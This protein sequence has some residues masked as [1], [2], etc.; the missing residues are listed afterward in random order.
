MLPYG[1]H[2]IE[3]DDIAAVAE[4]L[5]SDFL[6][7]GPKI[8][9]FEKALCEVTGAQYAVVCSSG[10][11]ALHLIARAMDL[12]PADCVIVPSITFLATANSPHETGARIVFA[13][14]N[15]RTGLMEPEH[16]EAALNRCGSHTPR[17]VFPV[18]LRGEGVNLKALRSVA[19]HNQ[20]KVIGDSC[21]A[22]GGEINGSPTGACRYEDAA[23]FSFHPV[24]TI[25]MGEGGAITTNDPELAEKTRRLRTHNVEWTA[26]I[27]PW[28]YEMPAPGFNY[29]ASALHC[30]LGLSQLKKLQRFV[31]RR[32]QLAALYDKA[33]EGLSPH[34]SVIPRQGHTRSG[35]HLYSVLIDFNALGKDRAQVM[36]E[37]KERRIGTQVHYIPVHTQPYYRALEPELHLPGAEDYY[38]QTLSLPLFPA[39]S[40]EDVGRVVEALK[41]VLV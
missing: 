19:D 25:A 15:A 31:D 6:T 28:A 17:A 24:K 23:T 8:E 5:R 3:E 18:H 7:S 34:L 37:L 16:L 27:G 33:L 21:H 9:E 13:D 26:D 41:D 20:I 1:R 29:R 32:A 11:A 38:A 14:V 30:A 10:T 40:D 12:G 36:N 4:T 35:W 39:M 22:I 2:L